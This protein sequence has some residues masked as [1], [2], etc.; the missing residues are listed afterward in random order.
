M[1]KWPGGKT[2]EYEIIRNFIPQYDR[3]IE[4]FFGGGAV[5]FN[6]TPKSAVIGDISENLMR[7]YGMIKDRNENFR[8]SLNAICDEWELLKRSAEHELPTLLDGFLQYRQDKS[9][10]P[11]LEAELAEC[12]EGV[13]GT[14][15]AAGYAIAAENDLK[16]Q[17]CRMV[18]DKFFRTS[19]NEIKNQAHLSD[20]DLRENLLTGFTSGYY[21]HLRERLNCAEKGY[22]VP[23]TDEYKTAVFYFVRE[24][25]YGSMFRYNQ[26]GD[27]N[28]PYGGI[29]YNHKDFRKKIDLLF[30]VEV[31]S[32]FEHTE[33]HCCD[34][35]EVL[36][37]AGENDFIFLDPPYD[38]DF[39]SYENRSFGEKDQRRLAR[40]L[41]DI[42]AKFLL[43]IRN[44]PLIDELYQNN[45]YRVYAFDHQYKYCV[46]G[47]NDRN[48]VHLIVTNYD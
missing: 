41:H 48:A 46:K 38:S 47:R 11:R 2:A 22:G 36:N 24:F 7:F 19:K 12:C 4:P 31:L 27:F 20:E 30:S 26:N 28:I 32:C 13:S 42:R 3:Y 37:E 8:R 15:S 10:R 40:R 35:E 21:M 6:L 18:S 23:V 25:C 34:F 45:G 17:L 5:F 43:I 39:S 44:S 16:K 1:I 29:A 9:I 33:L 14:V